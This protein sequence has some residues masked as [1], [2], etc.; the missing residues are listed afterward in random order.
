[1]VTDLTELLVAQHFHYRNIVD[2][3]ISVKKWSVT[4]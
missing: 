4:E 3:M 2:T 1:M